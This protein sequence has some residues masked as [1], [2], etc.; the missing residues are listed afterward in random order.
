M[1]VVEAPAE[2]GLVGLA[3]CT[4][5]GTA[6]DDLLVGTDGDD[7]ICGLGG[8][9]VLHSRGGDDVLRGGPGGDV[10]HGGRGSDRLYGGRGSD[11]LYGQAGDDVLVGGRG[12]DRLYGQAGNDLL[13]GGKGAD[14]LV[15]GRGEDWLDGGPGRDRASV[16]PGDRVRSVESVEMVGEE[17]GLSGSPGEWFLVKYL[18]AQAAPDSAAQALAERVVLRAGDLPA[19]QLLLLPPGEK[20]G[21]LVPCLVGRVDLSGLAVAAEA[22]SLAAAGPGG[23]LVY[24]NVSVFKDEGRAELAFRRLADAHTGCAA[25]AAEAVEESGPLGGLV[26]VSVVETLEFPALGEESAAWRIQIRLGDPELG[27]PEAVV[28]VST[29]VVH[30]RAGRVYVLL[31]FAGFPAPFDPVL[32]EQLAHT[33]AQRI[34]PASG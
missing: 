30:V 4:I 15:G 33:I 17:L 21:D 10:L 26:G 20:A 14:T 28:N 19:G 9:D 11:R 12:R 32:A 7:V 1:T 34:P 3:G 6:G 25:D 13:H 27:G 16:G 18:G 23:A 24:S 31:A 5:T 8:D 22:F 29:D 2:P